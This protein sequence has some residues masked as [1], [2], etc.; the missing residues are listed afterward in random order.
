MRF[1][2]SS[3]RVRQFLRAITAQVGEED[4][5]MVRALLTPAQVALF[6]RMPPN[7]QQHAIRVCRTLLQAGH[8][9]PDLLT[10]ALLHDVGKAAGPLPLWQRVAVVLLE[11]TALLDRVGADGATGWRRGFALHR[12]HPEI[13]A[14]WAE[15]AGA[16][17]RTVWLIRHHQE[18]T[19]PDAS[20]D[21]L[22][23]LALLQWADN[24]N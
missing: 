20:P 7:D 14:R 16:S 21:L 23:L 2:V 12:Q 19:P 5:Q 18:K 1:S 6:R 8:R 11:G 4:R 3:Y 17:P 24:R 9:D 22:R 15:E 10:A 13:G